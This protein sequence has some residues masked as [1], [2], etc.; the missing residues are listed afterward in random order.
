MVAHAPATD[1]S[2]AAPDAE[3]S[4]ADALD[5]PPSAE[6][7]VPPAADIPAAIAAADAIMSGNDDQVGVPRTPI[8]LFHPLQVYN[9]GRG[10]WCGI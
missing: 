9:T 2:A 3:A 5:A 4:K 10:C 8:F 1:D 6:K 7:A